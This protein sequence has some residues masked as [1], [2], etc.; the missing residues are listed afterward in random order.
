MSETQGLMPVALSAPICVIRGEICR[1]IL[2]L[3][4]RLKKSMRFLSRPMRSYVISMH[5]YPLSI[6]SYAIS[7]L[8]LCSVS[9]R[10]RLNTWR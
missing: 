8:V 4:F 10:F 2:L 9:G 5:F 6:H 3:A 7:I 1:L